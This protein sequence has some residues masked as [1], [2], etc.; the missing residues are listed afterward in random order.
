MLETC[1]E[2]AREG[3][4]G[5]GLK[6]FRWL[7]IFPPGV[8]IVL[9]VAALVGG[10]WYWVNAQRPAH[11]Q[12]IVSGF[13]SIRVFEG[14]PQMNHDGSQLTYVATGDQGSD[15]FLC[16][17]STGRKQIVCGEKGLQA[18]SGA[19]DLQARAWAPDD[20]SFIYST[21]SNLF[22]CPLDTNLPT[23]QLTIDAS[24]PSDLVWLNH[25]EF[26]YLENSTICYAKRQANKTNEAWIIHKL[27]HQGQILNLTAIDNHTIAWLQEDYICRL[28]LTRD[29][30]DTNN[31][32]DSLSG[33]TYTVPLTNNLL[34]WLDASCLDQDD[35]SSVTNLIDFS[36]KK[37]L[38][39]INQNPPVFN[40]PDSLGALNGKGTIHFESGVANSDA[41]GLK[42]RWRLGVAGSHPRTIFAVMRRDTG[43]SMLVN[44]GGTAT[45][46]NFF[47]LC[48]QN[49][50][51]YLPSGGFFDRNGEKTTKATKGKNRPVI[52][53]GRMPR[54]PAVWHMLG[55]VYDGTNCKSYV[56]GG[57]SG[58]LTLPFETV[59]KEVE[60]GLRV[61]NRSW[62]NAAVSD[63]DFAELL[64]YNRALSITEQRQVEDYLSAK[65]FGSRPLS[66]QSPLVWLDPQLNGLTGFS[67]SKE[68][69]RLLLSRTERGRDSLWQMDTELGTETHPTQILQGRLLRD[70]QWTGIREFAYTSHELDRPGLVLTDLA[71]KGKESL[72]EHGNIEWFKVTPDQ[73]QVL[74]F[75][76][77][78]NEP[79]AGIWRYD[80][81]SEQLQPIVP[82]SEH[83]STYATKIIPLHA[84]VKLPSGR[85]VNCI[86]YPPANFDRHKK[87]PLLLGNTFLRD[88]L[89]RYQ[90]PLWAPAVAS[91]G[92]YVVI[93]ERTSWFKGVELWGENV[94]GV[95]QTLAQDPC[96]DR[97]QV[98]LIGA[99]AETYY[100]GELVTKTPGLWKGVI[101][102]NPGGL[103]D[104][105][106]ATQ[107][108]CRPRILI[109]VGSE[110]HEDGRV[111]K[112]QADVLNN[113]VI[114]ENITHQGEGHHL[115]GNTAQLE[116]IKTMVHF[117]FEE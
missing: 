47:G 38:A 28:D 58:T 37:N 7:L 95:F 85:S 40:A 106:I 108:Q 55:M 68:T 113:G 115:V 90:A 88:Q 100:M 117:I 86:I 20:N 59:D 69:K 19:F 82:A 105:S 56:N 49:D 1:Y 8:W 30:T 99:S 53:D 4:V 71:G 29:I 9:A 12:E 57:L 72:F 101:F 25:S 104:F 74:F 76:N 79:S 111:Q 26:V 67:Y 97:R 39:I 21:R 62:T 65:W 33:N 27:P 17:T 93:I 18:R 96:I 63:G 10:R 11:R 50:F 35:Q 46:G 81:R 73:K 78:S 64:I 36:P 54:L 112:Y 45:N 84:T 32:F 6:P 41:T 77:V 75:G 5:Y 14:L 60:I 107:R 91:C 3:L 48:D 66:P 43:R 61:A 89:Y 114:V 70:V 52:N 2:K 51:L 22:V 116:R 80:L 103:P 83:P 16:D 98:Y 87:Y 34:L 31:P 13:G 23:T 42:T 94:M 92:A 109:S 24:Q 110:E 44:I 15:L 102:L